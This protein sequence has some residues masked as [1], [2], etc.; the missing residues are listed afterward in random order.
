ML[1][2]ISTGMSIGGT[3]TLP[4]LG[5]LGSGAPATSRIISLQPSA[6]LST[7]TGGAPTSS[8]IMALQPSATLST[9]ANGVPASSG[10]AALQP[11]VT[12]STPTYDAP[13]SSVVAS[14]HP[15]VTLSTPTDGELASSGNAALQSSVTLSTPTYGA[16]A[17]S[18]I[19]ALPPLGFSTG[20]V[21]SSGVSA[22]QTFPSDT[23]SAI[24]MLPKPTSYEEI[25]AWLASR[26]QHQ[27]GLDTSGSAAAGTSR[28]L[29]V[30]PRCRTIAAQTSGS[31]IA[32]SAAAAGD[33]TG[34]PLHSSAEL[35]LN[36]QKKCMEQTYQTS[37][38]NELQSLRQHHM[39][40]TQQQQQLLQ[41]QQQM[42][43]MQQQILSIDQQTI[44]ARQLSANPAAAT[45][46]GSL[47]PASAIGGASP[48]PAPRVLSGSAMSPAAE[49][50]G[51]TA[52]ATSHDQA[53]GAHQNTST[54]VDLSNAADICI[55]QCL[56][57]CQNVTCRQYLTFVAVLPKV[58]QQYCGSAF[59]PTLGNANRS[60]A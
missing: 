33:T 52:A 14:L 55:S 56:R 4:T 30:Q 20:D 40:S 5:R 10:I 28:T 26:Q 53:S 35:L 38:A 41:Q 3:P 21:H 49:C 17:S 43:D 13:A 51:T 47:A 27:R 6:T 7:P 12:L 42:T 25:A 48:G 37:A 44:L 9:P 22:V 54:T 24:A 16:P 36:M 57:I 8:G 11:S 39:M 2:V 60:C 15:S 45:L 59:K 18:G 34:T 29:P 23:M 31:S 50:H 58:W 46:T 32:A 1:M 19:A